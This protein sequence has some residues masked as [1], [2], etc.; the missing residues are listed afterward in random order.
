MQLRRVLGILVAV[1]TLGLASTASAQ[2]QAITVPWDP[3]DNTQPHFAYN[4]HPT[5]FKAI[6]RGGDN[7]S[8]DI[9]W[10][11][12]GD[13]QYDFTE[14]R[15]DRYNLSTSYTYPNVA[16]DTTYMAVIEVTS[17]GETTTA[18]YPVR[19]IADVPADPTAAT[20]DQLAIMTSVALDDALWWMH[21]QMVGRTGDE[22]NQLTGA[23]VTG[24]VPHP[25][26]NYHTAATGAFLWGMGLKRHLMAYPP[27][28]YIGTV[29]NVDENT[30]RWNNDPYA[31]SVLRAV[32]W[33]LVN[34]AEIITGL[35]AEDE[36]NRQG[37]YPEIDK[38]PILGTDDGVGIWFGYTLGN[39]Y[40]YPMGHVMAGFSA[41]RVSGYTIQVGDPNYILGRPFEYIVQQMVDAVVWAQ[42]DGGN[43][44]GSWY[45]TP[46]SA[47]DD[48]S[49]TLWG[50][51]SMWYA[52]NFMS[53]SG[54][55]VPNRAMARA[56]QYASNNSRVPVAGER[57]GSY[58]TSIAGCAFTVT[59]A[60]LLSM[61]WAGASSFDPADT[62]I[63][64]PGYSALTR[65]EV[66]TLYNEYLA[67]IG[68]NWLNIV[69]GNIGWNQG[70][71]EPDGNGMADWTRTDMMGN[72]YAMLHWHEAA[73]SHLPEVV[74]YGGNPWKQQMSIYLV[75][76]QFPDG[77]YRSVPSGNLAQ[78][79]DNE[80]T[81]V[82][83]TGWAIPVLSFVTI[84][85]NTPPE[86]PVIITP[87]ND[88]TVNDTNPTLIIRNSSDPDLDQ[89]WYDFQ[90]ATD[91]TFTTIID[92]A[93]MVPAGENGIT[94]WPP[95]GPL[96]EDTGYCWRSRA[97]DSQACSEW[98]H[99]CFLVSSENNPPP[100]PV[101]STP[102]NGSTIWTLNPN[103][104]WMPSIDPEGDRVTYSIEVFDSNGDTVA[105]SSSIGG[106]ITS[107]S[108]LTD[109]GT[110]TWHVLAVDEFGAMS[111]WS[112]EFAFTVD[113]SMDPNG[114]G[115][116]GDTDIYVNG[117][118]CAVGS[119]S[120]GAPLGV[121]LLLTFAFLSAGRRRKN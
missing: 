119:G 46:N 111:G 59:A 34:R 18:T 97:C 113:L 66:R 64:F 29:P 44:L 8:Y 54:V 42:G 107:L 73:R 32:N 20:Q 12:D 81:E 114:G 21:T 84:E 118:G 95:L 100:P 7:A 98:V 112:D 1:C 51:T 4:G 36:N 65:G 11:F 69:T 74:D 10:D 14:N 104:T 110:Y 31:E 24:Y 43:A 79:S 103:Y 67:F 45:Y 121:L 23:Q 17:N 101:L 15:A 71:W 19:V 48:L 3:L 56:V 89:L 2:L 26:G 93:L 60:H 57:C 94:E 22:N 91:D 92:E 25:N 82:L 80:G 62:R 109:L 30:I 63:A 102:A 55:I 9:R 16:Q 5:I 117:G 87:P 6:A 28:G 70:L 13:G 37:F 72:H 108:Q 50:M 83:N 105:A 115:S 41:L 96:D 106:T 47:T 116:G 90:L 40:I 85:E 27:D 61:S 49:T 75:N 77:H 39:R 76:N 120:G 33:L 52:H 99:A 35:P 38:A 53:G 78:N 86:P 88:T 68:N 58:Q